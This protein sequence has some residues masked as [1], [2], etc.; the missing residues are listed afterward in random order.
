MKTISSSLLFESSSITFYHPFRSNRELKKQTVF[1]G[2]IN[3][4]LWHWQSSGAPFL[5]NNTNK[6]EVLWRFSGS[7]FLGN[8]NSLEIQRSVVTFLAAHSLWQSPDILDFLNLGIF[9]I[10][11]FFYADHIFKK[12]SNLWTF[13]TY[14]LHDSEK[15]DFL[16]SISVDLN[17]LKS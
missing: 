5:G 12:V 1:L 9:F 7:P 13:F 6:I 14:L 10:L 17:Q 8:T 11:D 15:R 4:D 2:N 3:R 16:L